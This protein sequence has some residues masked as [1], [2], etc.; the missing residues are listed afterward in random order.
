MHFVIRFEP[1]SDT[2][3]YSIYSPINPIVPDVKIRDGDTVIFKGEEILTRKEFYRIADKLA[4]KDVNFIIETT[5]I[6][7]N[8]PENLKYIFKNYKIKEILIKIFSLNFQ[9]NDRFFKSV[10]L[11][12]SSLSGL[13]RLLASGFENLSIITYV[14]E[15][16]FL[17]R[18]KM[19]YDFKN[20]RRLKYLYIEL[21]NKLSIERRNSIFKEILFRF[22]EAE[23]IIVRNNDFE[24]RLKD[25]NKTNLEIKTDRE[26]GVL[27]LVLRN[28]CTNNCVF[29]TT[30][31]VQKAFKSPLPFDRA[32]SVIKAISRFSKGLKKRELFE[33]VAVEPLEHPDIMNILRE[34]KKY[35]FKSIRLFTHGRMLKTDKDIDMLRRVGVREILIPISFYSAE[36]A[37]LTVGDTTAYND[38][39]NLLK[40]IRDYKGIQFIFNIM[41]FKQN[42]KDIYKIVKFLKGCG[43]QDFNFSLALPSIEDERYYLPYALKFTDLIQIIQ[44]GT[45]DKKLQKGIINSLAYII[46]LCVIQRYFSKSIVTEIESKFKSISSIS[47]SAKRPSART[48]LT[49]NC[50]KKGL[51]PYGNFCVGVNEIYV[52]V[53]GDQEFY[54]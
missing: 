4:R 51:C 6:T 27:N 9:V 42:Y 12:A 25:R 52:R 28:F 11:S 17:N 20:E 21:D 34:A 32:E 15:R 3:N 39:V 41:I 38:I 53:F 7:F 43:V 47:I 40:L 49:I 33:I 13:N 18:I 19:I 35:G 46:P 26:S 30:R 1:L 23:D 54:Y 14:D 10:G 24:V 48:K 16:D 5:G 29:C 37:R 22:G 2:T 36:S 8:N 44:N 50:F 45:R 31:I